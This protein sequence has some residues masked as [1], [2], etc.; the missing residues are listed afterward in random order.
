M[1]TQSLGEIAYN[2]FGED[3]AWLRDGKLMPSWE[4][5]PWTVQ[6]SWQA[7]GKAV[8]RHLQLA[9]NAA[10]LQAIEGGQSTH[11]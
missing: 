6:Q 11:E 1:A 2:A 9:K 5:V 8:I 10:A 7:A 3:Q 4:S